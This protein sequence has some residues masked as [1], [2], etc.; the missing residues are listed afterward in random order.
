RRSSPRPRSIPRRRRSSRLTEPRKLT[1]SI[2]IWTPTGLSPQ[3]RRPSWRRSGPSRRPTIG[4]SKPRWDWTRDAPLRSVLFLSAYNS[5]VSASAS[6]LILSYEE[7]ARA[8]QQQAAAVRPGLAETVPL[9]EALDRTLAQAVVADRDQPPFARS[10][11][12]G[13]ACRA[14]DLAKSKPL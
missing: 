4:R 8:V 10:T 13:F 1:R 2:L 9:L 7:A 12:D 5:V 14:A 3:M 6:S 11:R